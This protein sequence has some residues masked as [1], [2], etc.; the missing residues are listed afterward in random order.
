M[1]TKTGVWNLQQVR[2]KQLQSLWE[3]STSAAGMYVFGGNGD[4]GELGQNNNTE[5]SSPTQ[6]PGITNWSKVIMGLAKVTGGITSD[7]NCGY[8]DKIVRDN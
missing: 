6:V 1:A 8:G 4:E 2:D 5:Y 3:Y 7:G